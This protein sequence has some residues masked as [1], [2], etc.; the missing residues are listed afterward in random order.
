MYF[1]KLRN[2]SWYDQ[3]NAVFSNDAI[4]DSKFLVAI[5]FKNHCLDFHSQSLFP[6]E[7][8]FIYIPG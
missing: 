1:K 4:L 6:K 5:L 3:R 8:D 2:S 7:S